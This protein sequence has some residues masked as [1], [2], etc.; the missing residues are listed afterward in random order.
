MVV[1]S[2]SCLIDHA[3]D[4]F[5]NF[6]RDAKMKS[7]HWK[8][9]ILHQVKLFKDDTIEGFH[10]IYDFEKNKNKKFRKPF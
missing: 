1:S 10:V 7:L 2:N 9:K 3:L 5:K 6:C 8:K 4:K